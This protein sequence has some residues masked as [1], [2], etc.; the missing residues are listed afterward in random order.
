MF[1]FLFLILEN[2]LLFSYN[3]NVYISNDNI[4][5]VKKMHQTQSDGYIYSSNISNFKYFTE[6]SPQ[7]ILKYKNEI[8]FYT[9]TKID[10]NLS[11]FIN[12]KVKNRFFQPKYLTESEIVP[13]ENQYYLFNNGQQTGIPGE[14]INVKPAWEQG[15]MGNGVNFIINDNGCLP[16]APEIRKNYNKSNSWNYIDGCLSEKYKIGDCYDIYPNKSDE[17][18]FHGSACAHIVGGDENGKCGPGVAPHTHLACQKLGDHLNQKNVKA[19]LFSISRIRHVDG[20]SNSW[21]PACTIDKEIRTAFCPQSRRL[22]VLTSAYEKMMQ[23]GRN[24]KGSTIVF[25]AGNEGHYGDDTSFKILNCER[26]VIGVAA[27]TNEGMRC[28]YSSR[29][30]SIL[31]NAPSGGRDFYSTGS[32]HVPGIFTSTG[33]ECMSNFSGTSA[34]TPQVSGVVSLLYDA[35]PN[36]G[37]RDV[38]TI[39][40]ATATVNDPDCPS[41]V[42]N[43]AGFYHSAYHGFGRVNAGKA[44][45]LAKN[46]E[47]MSDEEYVNGSIYNIELYQCRSPPLKFSVFIRDPIVNF[48]EVVEFE[49]ELSANAMGFLEIY[50]TSPQGTRVQI[51]EN[52]INSDVEVSYTKLIVIRDFLGENPLGEWKVEIKTT[53][54]IIVA[55]LVKC[56]ITAY[57]PTEFKL[58]SHQSFGKKY[59]NFLPKKTDKFSLKEKRM[60]IECGKNITL[61]AQD[62]NPEYYNKTVAAL[63]IDRKGRR[64][65]L[66]DVNIS[67]EFNITVPC[68]FQPK[69]LKLGLDLLMIKERYSLP[70]WVTPRQNTIVEGI[71]KPKKYETFFTKMNENISIDVEWQFLM[72][73]FPKSFWGTCAILSLFNH[74]KGELLMTRKIFNSGYFN[75]TISPNFSCP[76]C[77][78]VITPVHH[79]SQST[80]TTLTV[81]IHIIPEGRKTPKDREPFDF[82]PC[83]KRMIKRKYGFDFIDEYLLQPD[84]IILLIILAVVILVFKLARNK[85]NGKNNKVMSDMEQLVP[86]NFKIDDI[87]FDDL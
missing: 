61:H 36:L 70:I 6:Y 11:N 60:R 67:E 64:I 49:Y 31:V 19:L 54:C 2:D 1:H 7:K 10:S 69:K 35:N 14:D 76:Q 22:D 25:A 15:I 51:K 43:K 85:R 23:K 4:G 87:R 40:A 29:G 75:L 18:S 47:L 45:E 74:K 39:L 56:V 79:S 9:K 82:D 33:T 30:N 27:S 34:A 63:L 42:R 28:F 5:S 78:M 80:C 44:V 66:G 48:I 83:E 81:P 50:L 20:S 77:V 84:F 38:Q 37:W 16:D 62:I 73:R 32:L 55:R 68:I 72:D 86:S 41:W 59:K 21:G 65:S 26:F 46:W 57:G 8:I 52:S 53:G 58:K 24:G 12:E 3:Q 13:N 17:F 71:T